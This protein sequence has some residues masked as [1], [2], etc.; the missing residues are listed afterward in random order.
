MGLCNF[1]IWRLR[2]HAF[3]SKS[4]L[5]A[6]SWGSKPMDQNCFFEVMELLS[7]ILFF[8]LRAKSFMNLNFFLR[9]QI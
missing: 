4:L 2:F 9:Y 7:N 8:N 1:N 3:N 5:S 6:E